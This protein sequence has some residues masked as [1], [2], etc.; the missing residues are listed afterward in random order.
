MKNFLFVTSGGV[1]QSSASSIYVQLQCG[2]A[3]QANSIQSVQQS[4]SA[5]SHQFSLAFLGTTPVLKVSCK[6]LFSVLFVIRAYL[7]NDIT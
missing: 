7:K 6:D 5:K 3:M 2:D 1:F 4:H